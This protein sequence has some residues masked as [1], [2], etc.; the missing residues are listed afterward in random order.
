M[1][2]ITMSTT[3]KTNTSTEVS[4][5]ELHTLLTTLKQEILDSKYN[6]KPLSEYINNYKLSQDKNTET[7]LTKAVIHIMTNMQISDNLQKQI[8]QMQNRTKLTQSLLDDFRY[9]IHKIFNTINLKELN[10]NNI[11]SI[12]ENTRIAQ[13]STTTEKPLNDQTTTLKDIIQ[14]NWSNKPLTDTINHTHHIDLLLIMSQDIIIKHIINKKY[15]TN[16]IIIPWFLDNILLLYHSNTQELQKLCKYITNETDL[17]N[18]SYEP[19]PDDIEEDD[20]AKLSTK[21]KSERL[22]KL[23]DDIADHVLK[24]KLTDKGKTNNLSHYINECITNKDE[25]SIKSLYTAIYTIT[26]NTNIIPQEIK[27]Q[28]NNIKEKISPEAQLMVIEYLQKNIFNKMDINK[29]NDDNIRKIIIINKN[30]QILSDKQSEDNLITILKENDTDIFFI[31]L[32]IILKPYNNKIINDL[33]WEYAKKSQQQ[34]MDLKV[35]NILKQHNNPITK[36]FFD[37]KEDILESKYDNQP[38][39]KYINEFNK[40]QNSTVEDKLTEAVSHILKNY[41]INQELTKQITTIKSNPQDMNE[42]ITYLDSDIFNNTNLKDFGDKNIDSLIES[43]IPIAGKDVKIS[44]KSQM[45]NNMD[46]LFFMSTCILPKSNSTILK[47]ILTAYMQKLQSYN[48]SLKAPTGTPIIKPTDTSSQGSATNPIETPINPLTHLGHIPDGPTHQPTTDQPNP[49]EEQLK[50]AAALKAKQDAE[51]QELKEQQKAEAQKLKE[52]Q[53]LARKA[54]E[55][56]KAQK[57]KEQ[58]KDQ[59]DK[60]IS[61]PILIFIWICFSGGLSFLGYT[62]Y[63]MFTEED[64]YNT[65]YQQY[66]ESNII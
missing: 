27:D 53:E 48:P 64:I 31:I 51:A 65:H 28:I 26:K 52:Q 6:N 20:F 13:Y 44:I 57:L 23:F 9:A 18:Q 47:S 5:N 40:K 2:Y 15:T 58:Q 25:I 1:I 4:F 8:K 24:I 29:L 61:I 32:N 11:K 30:N 49:T 12:I 59:N 10:N 14:Y 62:L 19:L 63:L 46:I 36:F 35:K 50:I 16:N 66:T 54:Q 21:D 3:H 22:K 38:L 7:E 45:K 42:I 41:A 60:P 34:A 55:D 39:S 37:L 56:A 17:T 33:F 43:A